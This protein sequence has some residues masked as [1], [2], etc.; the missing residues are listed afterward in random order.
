M[1]ELR[2]GP[3][4][5]GKRVAGRDGRDALP[6]FAGAGGGRR[7]VVPGGFAADKLSCNSAVRD[8]SECK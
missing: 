2:R 7:A 4:G 5:A 8:H 3:D 6:E 1:G